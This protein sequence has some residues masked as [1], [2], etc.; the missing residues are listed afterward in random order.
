[1]SAVFFD[2]DGTLIDNTYF[3]T[4]AW[5]RACRELEVDTTAA[6]LHRLVGMGGDQ[7]TKTLVGREM[8]ELDEAHG[9]HMKPFETEAPVLDGGADLIVELRRRGTRIGV[10]TSASRD[11]AAAALRRV[12][13]D[14]SVI[15]HNRHSRRYRCQQ[16]CARSHRGGA[17]AVG[18]A[19]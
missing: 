5:L 18:R 8:P 1:M 9:R 3:H 6:Q 2:V 16:T 4:I 19:T 10:A 13:P 14:M 7:L 17:A 12:V 15:R 11:A